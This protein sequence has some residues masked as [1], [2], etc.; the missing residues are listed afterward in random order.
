MNSNSRTEP[1]AGGASTKENPRLP[2]AT[3]SAGL[4]TL[5][6]GSSRR[7][8]I[9][10][11]RPANIRLIN[12]RSKLPRLLLAL[13]S[14]NDRSKDNNRNNPIDVQRLTGHS[15]SAGEVIEFDL[16]NVPPNATGASLSGDPGYAT[17]TVTYAITGSDGTASAQLTLGNLAGQYQVTASC[18]G[19]ISATFNATA[20]TGP[21]LAISTTSLPSIG[22]GLA[23]NATLQATGGTGTGYTW[24]V[25]AGSV[26]TACDPN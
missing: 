6:R 7:I 23:Y 11:F 16:T 1:A 21:S 12:R 25:L 3:G 2:Y 15:I 4:A 20:L 13:S 24:C 18:W 5:V 14:N 10:R 26:G 9:M 19:C 17:G 8:K 22:A